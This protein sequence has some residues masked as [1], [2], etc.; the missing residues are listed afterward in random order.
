MINIVTKQQD[1]LSIDNTRQ[2]VLKII[3][4]MSYML[5]I[6]L[7][8]I[9]YFI[10]NT[11]RT[12]VYNVSVSLDKRIPFMPEF[13]I[14]YVMWYGYVFITLIYFCFK[15]Y[16]K[17]KRMLITMLI[18]LSLCYI[19]YFLFPTTVIRPN[20]VGDSLTEKLVKII[21]QLDKP[22]NCFPSIHVLQ[23]IIVMIFVYLQKEIKLF[24]KV[25]MYII[26]ISI[27]ISTVFVKQ[28]CILDAVGGILT[29][30]IA[31]Y[32]SGFIYNR[33]ANIQNN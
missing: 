32:L 21:Y 19:M 5:S 4:R 26:G 14:P 16:E 12:T 1:Y 33:Y 28:H 18:G 24:P 29:A 9:M 30:W 6:P 13:I 11:K 3:I 15:Y 20:S 23:T 22:Y 8:N 25:F 7:I 2:N 17:Y 10:L 31:Y 27:I